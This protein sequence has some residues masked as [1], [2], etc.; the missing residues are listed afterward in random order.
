MLQRLSKKEFM[1]LSRDDKQ[2]WIVRRD[3]IITKFNTWMDE[4]GEPQPTRGVLVKR[5][6]N[7]GYKPRKSNGSVVF[8]RI[9][10]IDNQGSDDEDWNNKQKQKY[11]FFFG[12]KGSNYFGS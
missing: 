7:L 6:E 12:R 10:F 4:N 8:D 2:E 11:Q 5:L 9:Q 1:A 3:E